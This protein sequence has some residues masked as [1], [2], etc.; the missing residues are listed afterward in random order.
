MSV[1]LWNEVTCRLRV[2]KGAIMDHIKAKKDA[3]I[4]FTLSFIPVLPMIIFAESPAN[5]VL[6][7]IFCVLF[8]LFLAA[9]IFVQNKYYRCPHCHSQINGRGPVPK[10]CV[11]C[12]ERL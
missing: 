4:I 5:K 7:V 1:L 6:L 8:A 2:K 11:D 10:F 12:G 9:G 3:N